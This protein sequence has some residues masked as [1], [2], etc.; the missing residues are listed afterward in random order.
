MASSRPNSPPTSV[1]FNP[2]PRD[3][4]NDDA[5]T[6]YSSHWS[7]AG[8]AD[9]GPHPVQVSSQDATVTSAP[10]ANAV[11][12]PSS[13]PAYPRSYSPRVPPIP[14]HSP[15][16]ANFPRMS[17]TSFNSPSRPST[18]GSR[19]HLP[20]LT[21]RAFFNP[22]SSQRLQ[23]QR[24]QRSGSLSETDRSRRHSEESEDNDTRSRTH[25]NSTGS[26]L[27]AMGGRP[28]SLR[29]DVD[30]SLAPRSRGTDASEWQ[31]PGNTA[32][33][34]GLINGNVRHTGRE[35]LASLDTPTG[36]LNGSSVDADRAYSTN[37]SPNLDRKSQ[38]SFRQNLMTPS[39]QDMSSMRSPTGH[40][41]LNSRDSSQSILKVVSQK[42]RLGKNWEYFDGNTLFFCGGRLQ[43]SKDKP[44]SAATAVFVTLPAALFFG[45]S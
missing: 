36:N 7:D 15:L 38:R 12:Q 35:S 26:V 28:L 33:T 30:E 2:A 14:S 5:Y 3:N 22:L 13:L 24:G 10:P 18:A 42:S 8:T 44:I 27:T 32:T 4:H 25:R 29:R 11:P 19:S 23:A 9:E 41:K 43:T 40:E 37:R 16:S 21:S 6:T 20:S 1:N 45:F 39:K 31:F 17:Q 34:R